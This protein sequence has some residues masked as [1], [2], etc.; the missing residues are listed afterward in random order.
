MEWLSFTSLRHYLLKKRS[1][2]KL[3]TSNQVSASIRQIL[4]SVCRKISVEVVDN[5][6]P[7]METRWAIRI[8]ES[9]PRGSQTRLYVLEATSQDCIIVLGMRTLI[10]C[11]RKVTSPI[12]KQGNRSLI[13]IV[14]KYPT[15]LTVDCNLILVY[16]GLVPNEILEDMQ[17]S[18]L[19]PFH[20]MNGGL[21]GANSSRNVGFLV[22]FN[23]AALSMLALSLSRCRSAT[24]LAK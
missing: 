2:E 14:G 19:R 7:L 20:W 18:L 4:R 24:K 1:M 9:T 21:L 22:T 5:K 6:V 13:R 8:F 16:C 12:D 23:G 11:S 10:D 15:D 17:T 3:Q